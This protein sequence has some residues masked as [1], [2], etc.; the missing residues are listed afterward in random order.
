MTG[1]TAEWHESAFD[2]YAGLA[3]SVRPWQWYKQAVLLVALIF[4]GLLF[5][6]AAWTNVLIGVLAFCSLAS[7]VY[8]FNDIQDVEEDRRHPTK[9]QRPIASGQLPVSVAAVAAVLL[10]AMGVA[11]SFLVNVPFG[12]LG[13]GYLGLNVLY[14]TLLGSL[15]FV[16]VIVVAVG[17]LIRAVAGAFAVGVPISA[18]LVAVILLLALVLALGKRRHDIHVAE[19][20]ETRDLD[21]PYDATALDQLLVIVMSGVLVFYTLY[22]LTKADTLMLLTLPPAYY[23]LFRYFHLVHT[24]DVLGEPALIF[25]DRPTIAAIGIWLLV[26]VAV[27]YG[28]PYLEAAIGTPPLLEGMASW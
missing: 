3:M 25:R 21:E 24:T 5:D 15:L 6:P 10:A 7:A 1:E 22:V 8:L 12:L 23:G 4:G 28:A 2:L 17:Y 26:A 9:R 27:L 18:W 11:L 16:D 14:S 19:V 13:L 20:E